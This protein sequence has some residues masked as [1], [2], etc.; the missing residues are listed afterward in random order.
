MA[1]A[2]DLIPFIPPFNASYPKRVILARVVSIN[3]D[4]TVNVIADDGHDT[5][6]VAVPF[7]KV[8]PEHPVQHPVQG[9]FA[10][11][12]AIRSPFHSQGGPGHGAVGAVSNPKPAPYTSTEQG[13]GPASNAAIADAQAQAQVPHFVDSE[14]HK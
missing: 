13:T 6:H 3:G 12:A 14:V 4:G 9:P 10:F 1:T 2:G 7:L 11:D 5:P 8:D